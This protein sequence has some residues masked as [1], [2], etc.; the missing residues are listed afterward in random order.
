MY[1]EYLLRAFKNLFKS[2]KME[3]RKRESIY[4]CPLFTPKRDFGKQ[5]VA[6]I[7]C[8]C[9]RAYCY[10]HILNFKEEKQV[11][12]CETPEILKSMQDKIGALIFNR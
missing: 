3:S 5:K 9:V 2:E 6:H 8:I 4:I 12:I 7:C 10:A 11:R 1:E